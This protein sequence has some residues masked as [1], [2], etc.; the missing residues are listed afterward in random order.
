MEGPQS[1][2]EGGD[3]RTY[4][5]PTPILTAS[6]LPV[7]RQNGANAQNLDSRPV[8]S[9]AGRTRIVYDTTNDITALPEGPDSTKGVHRPWDS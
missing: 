6:P 2:E 9:V 4:P 1:Q 3:D 7:N 8:L 5:P